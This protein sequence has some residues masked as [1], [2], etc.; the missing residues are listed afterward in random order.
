MII[1]NICHTSKCNSRQAELAQ[2]LA[3]RADGEFVN[4]AGFSSENA[5]SSEPGFWG[6]VLQSWQEKRLRLRMSFLVE[7]K[8]V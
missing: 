4:E 5:S 6:R 1:F 3:E 8:D 2:I 7:T